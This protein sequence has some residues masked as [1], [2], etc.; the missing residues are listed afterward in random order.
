MSSA[1]GFHEYADECME[2]AKGAKTTKERDIYLQ[3]AKAWRY[4]A[5]VV[6]DPT[7]V[8]TKRS[9]QHDDSAKA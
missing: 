1:K 4:A 6:R 8:R 7:A 5:L 9:S 2:W 3:M